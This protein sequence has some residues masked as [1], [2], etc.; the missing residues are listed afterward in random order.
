MASARREPRLLGR[1][2]C[3]AL[4]AGLFALLVSLPAMALDVA[5][6]WD[7][8]QPE[9]SEQRFRQALKGANGDDALVLQTQI[10]RTFGLRQDF[11]GARRL[12]LDLQP[13]ISRAGPEARTRYHL[14]LGRTFAS[15]KHS[16]AQLT[17]DAT[18]QARQAYEA[19]LDLA[20]EHRLDALAIDAIHMFAFLDT[21]PADQLK[22]GLT[23]L[24]V[25]Q[26]SSQ[27]AAMRW[28]AS[29]R[30][31][32]GYALHQLGRDDEALAHFEQ[33]LALRQ[34]A[35]NA[36][37][38]HV[39]QWMVAWT[40]R[41]LGRTEQALTIQLQLERA[42]DETGEPDPHVFEELEALFTA[43]GDATRA[44]HYATRRRNSAGS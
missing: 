12:L 4:A 8:D 24:E 2:V 17:A 7:F 36:R 37:A 3:A 27:P 38:V 30:N 18:T 31:N 28:E 1:G 32:I 9:S 10:A 44:A 29:V 13:L 11:A 15:G 16:A 26:T 5:A 42:A 41:H 43:K 40:M 14:E 25:V 20:R 6:L 34:Q 21:A 33:A 19:A 23:A 39:A 22:W 35:G